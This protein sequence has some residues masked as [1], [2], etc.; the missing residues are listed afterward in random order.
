MGTRTYKIK[1]LGEY[2]G[3]PD[4]L[5]FIRQAGS[6][7]DM[8][9]WVMQTEHRIPRNVGTRKNGSPHTRKEPLRTDGCYQVTEASSVG[10]TYPEII[11]WKV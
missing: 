1:I 8:L 5:E 9:G 2:D 3:K 7:T 11:G 6:M 4:E 10:M